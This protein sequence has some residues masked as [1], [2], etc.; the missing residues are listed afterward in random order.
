MA[1]FDRSHTSSYSSSIVTMAISCIVYKLKQDISRKSRFFI[2]N[3][4]LQ[5]PPRPGKMVGP[6]GCVNRLFT[7]SALQTD[8]NVSIAEH[9]D[10]LRNAR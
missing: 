6:R 9:L 3:S 2:P 8:G 10:L 1:P 4:T 5:P 7:R